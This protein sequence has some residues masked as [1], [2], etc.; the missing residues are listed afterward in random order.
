MYYNMYYIHVLYTCISYTHTNIYTHIC[1]YIYI[2][3]YV[4]CTHT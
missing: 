4:I 3:I 1:V 2:Y